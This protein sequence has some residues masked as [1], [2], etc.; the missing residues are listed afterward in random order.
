M[1]RRV[2]L[3]L[4]QKQNQT[5]SA[6][7]LSPDHPAASPALQ[8]FSIRPLELQLFHAVENTSLLVPIARLHPTSYPDETPISIHFER[9]WLETQ[10]WNIPIFSVSPET[11]GRGTSKFIIRSVRRT[12]DWT[13]TIRELGVVYGHKIESY[14]SK[15]RKVRI[16]FEI[17]GSRAQVRPRAL[18]SNKEIRHRMA[19]AP[20]FAPRWFS[21]TWEG[22]YGPV[23]CRL[24]V[25][26]TPRHSGET[27]GVYLYGNG[28]LFARALRS[29][30]VGYGESGNSILRDHPSCWR[31]HA[32]AFFEAEHGAD[33]PWQAPLKDGVSE[34]HPM[35][36]R[37]REMFKDVVAPYSRFAKVAKASE[38]V[39]YTVEWAEMTDQERAETLFGKDGTSALPRF[40]ALPGQLRKFSPPTTTE[41][42]LYDG[43][44]CGKLLTQL[45]EYA[46]FARQVLARRDKDGQVSTEEVLRSFNPKLFES[47]P[48]SRS[49][50]PVPQ[51]IVIR[52]DRSRKVVLELRHAHFDRLR[53]MFNVDNDKDAIIAAIR[54]AFEQ[55]EGRR[56]RGV[57]QAGR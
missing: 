2:R 52:K 45:D 6:C 1:N 11:V 22:E 20:E 57:R 49:Q 34:N 29:R 40:K 21:T 19:Y 46:T 23:T 16:D 28:R 43:A 9:G 48:A 39:P 41:T 14:A 50:A 56:M 53:T 13:D 26:L 24:L 30:A 15:N 4:G 54:F 10:D 44:M 38:L 27:S 42:L 31:L 8:L 47:P 32:Y 37:F 5:R 3:T 33:I 51:K 17:D 35:T 12:I 55:L 7:V 36:P 18:A 25:G